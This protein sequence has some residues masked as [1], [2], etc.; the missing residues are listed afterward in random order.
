MMTLEPICRFALLILLSTAQMP[1]RDPALSKALAD[2]EKGRILDSIQQFKEI[3]RSNPADDSSYFYLSTLYAQMSEYTVAER[4][5]KRA[6]EL[7]PR[8]GAHYY[9]LGLIRNRQKQWVAALDLFKQALELGTGGNDARVW[10]SIGDVQLELFDRD[11][12]LQAYTEALRLQP[13]DAQTRLALGQFYLGRGQADRATEQLVAALEIDPSL[14]AAYPLLGR[15]YRQSGD[16]ASAVSILKKA[17]DSDPGDQESRYA[18]GQTFVAMG[19][20]DEGRTELEKY[21]RIRQQITSADADY[22]AAESRL[23]EN[24]FA[25]AE[26]LLREALRLAPAYGPALQSLGTLLL[27]RAAAD[28]ALPFLE[29]AVQVNPLNAAGW[30]SVGTAYFKLGKVTEAWTAANYA[31]VLDEGDVQYQRLLHDIQERL[32]K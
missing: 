26:K 16:L 7:R 25:E 20:V 30:Y 21:E 19:H 5:L 29:H 31:V 2:L 27:E 28:K 23:S 8:Q 17:L 15:A 11:A 18:L 4:Y 22:K 6:M 13:R 14:R 1:A 32:K 9:Q 12:A 3:I 10:K 24:K